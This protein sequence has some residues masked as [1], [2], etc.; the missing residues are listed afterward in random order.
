MMNNGGLE[1]TK[2]NL[3]TLKVRKNKKEE[4]LVRGKALKDG[5]PCLGGDC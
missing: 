4:I 3:A 1:V 5:R 2:W